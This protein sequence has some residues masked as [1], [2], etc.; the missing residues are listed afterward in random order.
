MS[1]KFQPFPQALYRGNPR[2]FK[3]VNSE[4]E[5]QAAFADGWQTADEYFKN[6]Q[7]EDPSHEPE[8]PSGDPEDLEQEPPN[9][10]DDPFNDPE[11]L[12]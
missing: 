7:K 1:K 12:A 6:G 9:P 3:V 11:D 8:D 10:V 4:D 5:A 2:Q